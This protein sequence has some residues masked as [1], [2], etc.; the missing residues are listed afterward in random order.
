MDQHLYI[1]ALLDSL[2][3]FFLD[4]LQ[5]GL[6][7]SGGLVFEMSL[8]YI[9]DNAVQIIM[10]DMAEKVALL[11]LTLFQRSHIEVIFSGRILAEDGP[12]SGLQHQIHLFHPHISNLVDAD[13]HIYH[14]PPEIW[15]GS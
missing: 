6:R 5:R 13:F 1:A 15:V 8:P 9:P 2:L 3:K 7:V 10:Q 14:Q 4:V 11:Y 12:P